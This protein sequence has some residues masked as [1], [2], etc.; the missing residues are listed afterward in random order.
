MVGG[1]GK[2][3]FF[4]PVLVTPM[5][6]LSSCL[7]FCCLLL[8]LLPSCLLHVNRLYRCEAIFSSIL[9]LSMT[10]SSLVLCVSRGAASLQALETPQDHRYLLGYRV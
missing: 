10:F 2:H 7:K 8:C 5:Y 9:F 6:S 4:C 1:G 3:L